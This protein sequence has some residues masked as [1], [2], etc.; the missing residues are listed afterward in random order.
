M[1]YSFLFQYYKREYE[2]LAKRLAK[3]QFIRV[4]DGQVVITDYICNDPRVKMATDITGM[5]NRIQT[6]QFIHPDPR[7]RK[8]NL[9]ADTINL[10]DQMINHKLKGSERLSAGALTNQI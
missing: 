9:Q 4:I 1:S 5:G 3:K 10:Q 2:Q 6:D 7:N 8:I